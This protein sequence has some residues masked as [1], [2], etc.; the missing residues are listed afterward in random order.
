MAKTQTLAG[1][2][3]K[4]SY[5]QTSSAA[6]QRGA[7]PSDDLVPIQFKMPREFV[8]RFK[9]EALN[10]GLKLNALFELAFQA[11]TKS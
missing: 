8:V 7:Y 3:L 6:R 4:V 2:D 10:R 1:S 9:Q 11:L 5:P